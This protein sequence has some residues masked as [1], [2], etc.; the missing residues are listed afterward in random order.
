[1]RNKH[2]NYLYVNLHNEF[3][4]ILAKKVSKFIALFT[5]KKMGGYKRG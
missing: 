2:R 5:L 1:M 3:K 4:K